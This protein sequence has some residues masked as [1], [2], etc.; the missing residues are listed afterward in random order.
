MNG[1]GSSGLRKAL[2][3]R[4]RRSPSFYR[5]RA[6]LSDR[7]LLRESI[8]AQTTIDDH[9]VC[10]LKLAIRIETC[11]HA[12]RESPIPAKKPDP[13]PGDGKLHLTLR[14]RRGAP[15]TVIHG[16]PNRPPPGNRGVNPAAHP[17][18]CAP[19]VPAA[20]GRMTSCAAGCTAAEEVEAH[21]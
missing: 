20:P 13:T 11:V 4:C 16:H 9:L 6:V 21:R 14:Q 8:A 5:V 7:I 2:S 17:W 18:Q 12:K 10:I 1:L 15:R 19:H 3:L